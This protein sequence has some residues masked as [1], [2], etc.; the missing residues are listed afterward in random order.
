[1]APGALGF[2]EVMVGGSVVLSVMPWVQVFWPQISRLYTTP[3]PRTPK[4]TSVPC[5]RQPRG[6]GRPG[7]DSASLC[8]HHR[9][10]TRQVVGGAS[11]LKSS[12]GV[13]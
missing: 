6:P 1:M 3:L 9:S 5:T 12:C 10:E 13:F 11:P 2:L 8:C 4:Q 7:P